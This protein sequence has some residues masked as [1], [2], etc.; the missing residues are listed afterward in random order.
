[1]QTLILDSSQ[2]SAWFECPTIWANRG[3]IQI[4][5][6]DPAATNRPPDK[7]AAGSLGHK[8]LE[9]Y[10]D[11]LART[12]LSAIA[13]RAALDFD[14]DAADK[15]EP[16]FPL[17]VKLRKAVLDRFI[18]YM[19]VY[20]PEMD[21]RPAVKQKSAVGVNSAGLL[22]DTTVPDPLIEKGFSYNLYESPEYL[23]VLE[24]RIDFVGYAKDGTLLWMDHKWQIKEHALYEK[25]IQFRNYSL[26]TGLNLAV[27][28]YI[29]LHKELQNNTFVRQPLSFSS[30]EMR[31]W[32]QELIETYVAIAKQVAAG[33]FPQNRGA[34]GGSWGHA[35]QFTP[36]CE[37]YNPTAKQQIAK[38]DFTARKEW[39]PW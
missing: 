25:S 20:P 17:D 9:I 14:P 34:C 15:I 29:R 26:A 19:M 23:F 5:K 22:I 24:G 13:A 32:R 6:R 10:Y 16:Q 3:L 8:Y 12:K 33:Q 21:Y 30:L 28:N 7:M 31:Y 1:M 39:R 2:I 27:I 37:E 38:R 4:N 11:T 18:E 35:C 36:L